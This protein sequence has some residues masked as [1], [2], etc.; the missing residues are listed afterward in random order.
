MGKNDVGYLYGSNDFLYLKSSEP[1][2]VDVTL[3]ASD[4]LPLRK[5]K[6]ATIRTG[7]KGK[8]LGGQ[9]QCSCNAFVYVS[10]ANLSKNRIPLL[11][12]HRIFSYMLTAIDG[13]LKQ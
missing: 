9:A 12:L 4:D 13:I 7:L 1:S 8:F 5:V 3:P 2:V 6:F 11:S 10:A